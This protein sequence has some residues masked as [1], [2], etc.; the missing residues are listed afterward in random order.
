M[1]Q[2][3][4]LLV[5]QVVVGSGPQLTETLAGLLRT[6]GLV[7]VVLHKVIPMLLMVEH[8]AL[9]DQAL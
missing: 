6:Q 5:V 8:L 9:V 7:V 1:F 2:H 4:L 3:L